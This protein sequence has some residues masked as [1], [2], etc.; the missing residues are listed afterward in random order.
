MTS[1]QKSRPGG[2]TRA[3]KSFAGDT[4]TLP[5]G[6]PADQA[7]GLIDGAYVALVQT[8]LPG[9]TPRYRRRVFFTLPAAQR[10]V[11]TA[12]SSGL[13]AHLRVA[14]LVVVPE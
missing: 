2:N 1:A 5:A 4:T 12:H 14:R 7:T 10:A 9:R 3:A 13:D 11:E 6:I 8:R